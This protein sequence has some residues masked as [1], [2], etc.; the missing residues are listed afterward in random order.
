[1]RNE[2]S[3][4]CMS[5]AFKSICCCEF[6]FL[7]FSFVAEAFLKT[8]K[9]P[10]NYCQ[11]NQIIFMLFMSILERCTFDASITMSFVITSSKRIG[12]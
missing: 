7:G 4:Y 8:Y 5:I 3:N 2:D 12:T 1:M 11:K 10:A 6:V 9:S